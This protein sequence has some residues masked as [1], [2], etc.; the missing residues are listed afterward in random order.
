MVCEIINLPVIILVYYFLV[1][2]LVIAMKAATSGSRNGRSQLLF[3]LAH[4]FVAGDFSGQ[5]YRELSSF[6]WQ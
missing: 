3:S 2:E 5:M 1:D 4:L 6:N